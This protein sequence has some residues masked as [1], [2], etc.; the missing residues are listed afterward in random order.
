[1]CQTNRVAWAGP[2]LAFGT[3]WRKPGGNYRSN[4][5][6]GLTRCQKPPGAKPQGR[7]LTGWL[8][9]WRTPELSRWCSR[10][11]LTDHGPPSRLRGAQ[12]VSGC[13][14]V[15][16]V[17]QQG[18]G[19]AAALKRLESQPARKGPPFEDVQMGPLLG[20]GPCSSVFAGTCAGAPVA[21]KV[22]SPPPGSC[23]RLPRIA[24]LFKRRV[25]SSSQGGLCSFG[26]VAHMVERPLRMRE[27][28]SSI[29][30][31]SIVVLAP[32]CPFFDFRV[33]ERHLHLVFAP[34]VSLFWLSGV[35]KAP[36]SRF[37]S[38]R[39][40]FC[41]FGVSE[42]RAAPPSIFCSDLVFFSLP[43]VRNARG[44]SISVSTPV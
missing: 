20:R 42:T 26:G 14:P 2:P 43:G 18:K 15:L 10:P 28:Q 8:L 34:M 32:I 30:C 5:S 6:C 1:M 4:V 41:R 13:F 36:P 11:S 9:L 17:Q 7:E 29:L 21:I 3:R 44:A 37:C 12:L 33:S 23:G 27:A 22:A 25:I 35:R 39:A 38:V 31:T 19:A 40:L 16:Q 24:D